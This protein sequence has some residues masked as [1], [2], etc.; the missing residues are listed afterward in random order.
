VTAEQHHI[1][2]YRILRTLGAGGMGTVYL[3]EHI[4]LGR[5]AAIKTLQP[6]LSSHKELVERFFNEARAISAI[7]DPG[8]VQVFDFG[9]HVD[10]T[11]YIVMEFLEGEPLDARLDRLGKLPAAEALRLTRQIASSLAAAHA[12]GIIHRDLKPANV[13]VIRDREA[14]GGERTKILDF[15]IAKVPSDDEAASTQAGT[16][17][18]TPVYM[19]PEQCRGAATVDQRSDIYSVGCALFHMLTGIPPFDCE[20]VG[21]Y[22]AAHLKDEPP[23]P[24]ERAPG[25]SDAVDTLVM[26]CLEKRA[27]DRFQSMVE[28]QR[29]VEYVLANLSD[30]GKLG[31]DVEVSAT[32]LGEGFRSE[33][34]VNAKAEAPSPPSHSWFVDS[35]ADE[36]GAWRTPDRRMSVPQRIAMVLALFIG[37]AGGVAGAGYA[38]SDEENTG[39]VSP[40]VGASVDPLTDMRVAETA[41]EV[42][43]PEPLEDE[44][45][46][47]VDVLENDVAAEPPPPP[48]RP[49]PARSQIRPRPRRQVPLAPPP[50]ANTDSEDDLYDTR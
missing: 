45:T 37:V 40:A 20:T 33:Y 8:V 14:Q 36:S 23:R 35:L 18:G 5:R 3:G 7:S 27:E 4:L 21:D 31:A 48:A 10:G 6:S 47:A 25:L 49:H 22:I 9:Y 29:A 16:M 12:R 43:P 46:D 17:L 26:R 19:S 13:F 2:Q 39:A 11:A 24:S 44:P 32:P 30:P 15:G 28:L 38:L 41:H 42:T 34:D 50:A 1:G